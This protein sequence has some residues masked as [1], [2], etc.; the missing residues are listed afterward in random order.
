MRRRIQTFDPKERRKRRVRS[1]VKGTAEKP[2]IS[3]FR[4]N[5]YTYAQAVDDENRKTIASYSSLTLRKEKGKRVGKKTE[6][7]FMVGEKLGEI[8]LKKG[9]KQAVFDRGPYKYAGRVKN[10]AEGLRK[11]GIKI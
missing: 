6:E 4:S 8:L 2:R 1:K 3:V 10:V 9:I 7:A 11:A 5:K